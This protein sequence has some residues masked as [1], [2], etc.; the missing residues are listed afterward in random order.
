M[1]FL[2]I[3]KLILKKIGLRHPRRPTGRPH[4]AARECN[5]CKIRHTAREVRTYFLL[6]FCLLD[7][8]H[9]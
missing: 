5:S 8:L 9:E 7:T 4:F 2:K 6:L 3:I 1:K